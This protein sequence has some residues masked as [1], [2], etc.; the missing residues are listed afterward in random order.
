MRITL[1]A[2]GAVAMA[3]IL[4][5]GARSSWAQEAAPQGGTAA[6][7]AA[8]APPPDPTRGKWDSFLDPLRDFEDDYV[9]ATQKSIE[10]ATGIH[11]GAG[12]QEAW[13]WSFNTPPNQTRL[14]YDNF[15]TQ[16]SWIPE[17]GQVRATRPGQGWFIPGFGLTLTMGQTAPRI[18]SDWNGDGQINVGDTFEKNSFD[19]EEAYLTWTVPD[20]SP[21]LKGLSI[22]GGKFVT[23]LGAEVIEPWSNFNMSRS[24]LFS[25]AIPFTN[26]GALVTYP[27]TDKLSITGGPVMGWDQVPN[28]GGVSGMGNITWTATDQL[29]LAANGIYGPNQPSHLAR[30]R[31]VLD[32]V[33]TYKPIDPLT[34][35]LTYD[36]GKEDAAGLNGENAIWQGFAAVVNYNFTDRFSAAGRGEFF[37]DW[38]GARTGV[39]QRIWEMTGDLKYLITQH[40]Y[41][42]GEF[43]GDVSSDKPFQKNSTGFAGDNEVVSMNLTYLFL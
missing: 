2:C 10:D 22:K 38:N 35:S 3:T 41:V 18:K 29:T 36:Y 16:N 21:V 6:A 23:L 31:G 37:N 26:T 12:I 19:V 28:I 43:R 15:L 13:S 9:V 11:I 1:R 42:Q 40:L 25:F 27:I 7:P 17:I 33:A 8:N 4:S 14:I 39:N 5:V 32:L 24:L 34:I 20:D 30:K